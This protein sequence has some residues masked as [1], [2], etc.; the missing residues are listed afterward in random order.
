MRAVENRKMADRKMKTGAISLS[1]IFLFLSSQ[2]QHDGGK[3]GTVKVAL[4]YRR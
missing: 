1:A 2:A 4:V 3:T